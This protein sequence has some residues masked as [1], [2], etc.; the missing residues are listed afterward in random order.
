M[1]AKGLILRLPRPEYV[2]A[3]ET[4]LTALAWD[5]FEVAG[6]ESQ[7]G[8]PVA[9]AYRTD[10]RESKTLR[11]ISSE[12]AADDL[13][14]WSLALK[15]AGFYAENDDALGKAFAHAIRGVRARNAKSQAATP[16]TAVLALLQNTRGMAAKSNPWDIALM[17]ET[18]YAMGATDGAQSGSA[19]QSWLRTVDRRLASDRVLRAL[20]S[21]ALQLLPGEVA[22]RKLVR[23]VDSADVP[24]E[25]GAGT[26]F[27]WFRRHWDLITAPEWVDALPA[28][29]WVDWA[30]TLLRMALGFGYLWE[31]KWYEVLGRKIV[32]GS[33]PGTV[34]WKS[35]VEEVG[36]TLPWVSHTES[37]SIRDVAPLLSE[38]VRRG[39]AVRE[40][41]VRWFGEHQDAA[42]MELTAALHVMQQSDELRS[43]LERG[44]AHPPPRSNTWEA[45]RYAL[46]TRAITGPYADHYG[47]VRTTG[48]YAVV[49]P[50]TEW[51]ALIA[52]L[53]CGS[54]GTHTSVGRVSEELR[55][56]GV[57]PELSELINLLEVAGLA[58]GSA[59]ADQAVEV[60]S[61]Y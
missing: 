42:E 32:S 38:R 34:T 41:L 54:P 29:V 15:D 26:P 24:R 46:A 61:A 17:I 43:Q 25:L 44:L 37:V 51:C 3:P 27:A 39:G 9:M 28:R 35:L 40:V 50:G 59:D 7:G 47:L 13:P 49:A 12:P 36:E 18:M 55:E 48:R 30:T 8:K 23:S 2:A 5:R 56:L 1:K 53:A 16:L 14:A 45:V 52:S 11:F 33:I 6:L 31:A 10:G 19:S 58:R 20:D 60:Q 57:E 4:L 22:A 21:A